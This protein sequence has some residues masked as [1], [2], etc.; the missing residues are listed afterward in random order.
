MNNFEKLKSLDINT[1]SKWLNAYGRDDA[2]WNTWFDST[3]CQKCESVVATVD[4][5]FGESR[6]CK[7]AYCELEK[8]CR[9]FQDMDREPRS[10]DVVKMWLETEVE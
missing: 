7:F 5:F 10:R 6:E 4:D 1:F 3:Y 2:P 9:F 8:K